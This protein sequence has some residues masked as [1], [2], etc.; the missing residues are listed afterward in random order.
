MLDQIST[1]INFIAAAFLHIWPYLVIT[2]P[3]A[4]AVRMSGASRYINRA[5]QTQIGRASCRERV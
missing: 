3:L 4:V 2:I 5:F 1:I